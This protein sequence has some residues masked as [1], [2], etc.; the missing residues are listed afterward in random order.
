MLELLTEGKPNRDIAQELNLSENT[1]KVH[2]VGVFRVL[3]VTSRTE[4]VV[5]ATRLFRS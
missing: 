3:G 5:A 4:A 2:M 1:V